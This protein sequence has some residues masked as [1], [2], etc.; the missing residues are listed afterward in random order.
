MRPMLPSEAVKAVELT[1]RYA[2]VHGSPVLIG[3]PV[4]DIIYYLFVP[5]VIGSVSGA[6]GYH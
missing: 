5:I 6:I 4:V 3:N 2:K 1:S